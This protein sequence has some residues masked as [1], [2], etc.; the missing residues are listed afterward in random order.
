MGANI[1]PR[2]GIDGFDDYKKKINSLIQQGKTLD[3]EMKVVE[4][5]FTKESKAEEKNAKSKEVLEKQ[6]KV[7]EERTKALSEVVEKC[8]EMY[9]EQ[10]D[11]TQAWKEALNNAQAQLN[12]LKNSTDEQ[13]SSTEK[14]GKK[15]DDTKGK[16]NSFGSTLK[17]ILTADILKAGF[18][19]LIN[20]LKKL[21]DAFKSCLTDASA[22]ADSVNTIAAVTGLS[23]DTVQEFQYMSELLDVSIDSISDGLKETTNRIKDASTRGNE[24]VKNLKKMGISIKDAEGNIRDTEDVF[25]DFIEYLR[26][27]PNESQRT[28]VAMQIFGESARNLNP[29]INASAEEI[30]ALKKEAHDTGYVLSEDMLG[31]LQGMDDA[32]KRWQST[33]TSIKNKLGAALAPVVTQLVQKVTEF[34]RGLDWNWVATQIV[35]FAKKAIEAIK[36]VIAWLKQAYTWFQDN[37]LKIQVFFTTIGEAIKLVVGIFGTLMNA[38]KSVGDWFGTLPDKAKAAGESIA[39]FGV[40]I[41]NA[42]TALTQF[43]GSLIGSIGEALYNTG[44]EIGTWAGNTFLTIK[45]WV[46]N[47]ISTITNGIKS[48]FDKIKEMFQKIKDFFSNLIGGAKKWGTDMINGFSNGVTKSA[49]GLLAKIKEIAERIRGYLHF[50]RPD[51]GPLRDYETWMP[52]MIKGMANSIKANSYILDNAMSGLAGR[53]SAAAAGGSAMAGATINMTVNG[54]QGQSVNQLADIIMRRMYTQ[55]KNK[56]FSR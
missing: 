36:N 7:Q 46:N 42:I 31:S 18:T 38:I 37:K 41:W 32:T 2:I 30:A 1:G 8:A 39:N 33:V 24:W 6:I 51:Y 17:A 21:G 14:L 45:E 22:F 4:S 25:W 16:S 11:Q 44:Y 55:V 13:A 49:N 28:A 20:S 48:F 34:T 54:A 27:I 23:T 43:A 12:K 47:I 29:I 10:S 9:G 19:T 5:S 53:M 3:S 52:D 15:M 56:E 50:S 35:N 26:K 40:Q